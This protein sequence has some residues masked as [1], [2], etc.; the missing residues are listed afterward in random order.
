MSVTN[1]A[2][3][4]ECQELYTGIWV[5]RTVHWWVS[6]TVHW[7]VSVTNCALITGFITFQY[8]LASEAWDM[9][10]IA[11]LSKG[12][13]FIFV[14]SVWYEF[15]FWRFFMEFDTVYSEKYLST[16]RG[17]RCLHVRSNR[18]PVNVMCDILVWIPQDFSN[19]Q[20]HQDTENVHDTEDTARKITQDIGNCINFNS[21]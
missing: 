10:V 21:F 2:L 12:C 15:P 18:L 17:S 8:L 4:Y 5:S 1:R 14:F 20:A 6:Q 16:F 11:L 7:F 3:V 19:L 13:W 9:P